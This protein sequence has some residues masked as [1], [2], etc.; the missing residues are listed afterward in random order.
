MKTLSLILFVVLTAGGA[1]G[2]VTGQ[3]T[4][5]MK[6]GE[7]VLGPL[8]LV[9][10]VV[11]GIPE[12]SVTVWVN[13]VSGRV[14]PSGQFRI[15]IP[16]EVVATVMAFQEGT[17][18]LVY[19]PLGD[20]KRILRFN[21]LERGGMDAIRDLLNKR[22]STTQIRD[23]LPKNQAASEIRDLLP[24]NQATSEIRDLLPKNQ[25]TGEIRD[26][27]DKPGASGK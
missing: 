7:Q 11:N 2:Q 4:D 22:E 16:N 5:V 24:K 1:L 19:A 13:G 17:N 14:A 9:E 27:L 12:T 3:L 6:T 15:L 21:A 10:G 23:L 20:G 8:K 25:A 26:L 18:V